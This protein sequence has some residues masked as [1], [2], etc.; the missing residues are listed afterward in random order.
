MQDR[1]VGDIGDF[2]KYGLLR[3]ISGTASRAGPIRSLGVV[4]YVPDD[5]T[6]ERTSDGHGQNVGY[7]FDPRMRSKLREYDSELYDRLKE[8]VY[9]NRCLD[10]IK[11]REILGSETDREVAFCDSQLPR[12]PQ[13][14]RDQWMRDT[15]EK[16]SGT[17]IIFC[18]PDI[19]LKPRSR[20][21]KSP[22]HVLDSE[23]ESFLDTA[24]SST[25]VVY[26]YFHHGTRESQFNNWRR[27][28]ESV[29]GC[30]T[31][32]VGF[33]KPGADTFNHA[34]VVLRRA[35]ESVIEGRLDALIDTSPWRDRFTRDVL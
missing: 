8:I 7:L 10:A 22:Q 16:V 6:I 18:D 12:D 5:M 2:G 19:G 20:N 15:V 24:R 29:G 35:A 1:F 26:Q 27:L 28:K 21:G 9:E 30:D 32:V 3:A 34:L 11:A 13:E 25:V 33:T 4:W 14:R 23:I 31:T 17:D